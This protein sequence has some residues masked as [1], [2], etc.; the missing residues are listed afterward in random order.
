MWTIT[1][2]T[3]LAADRAWVRDENG[4]DTW[5][6][7][8]KGT[9]HIHDDGV[10][11]IADEQR[12]VLLLPEFLGEPAESSLV[13]DADLM[14]KKLTT[15]VLVHGHAQAPHAEPVTELD[16]R[17]Q[18]E[19]IDKT[20]RVFGPRQWEGTLLGEVVSAPQPFTEIPLDYEHAFGGMD[21]EEVSEFPVGEPRNPVGIGFTANRKRIV[22]LPVANI[23]NPKKRIANWNDRPEPA[24]LGPIPRH[25]PQR[26]QY[27]GTY[28]Q[29]W[30]QS[31]SPLLPHD[32]DERFYQAAPADQQTSSFLR[33]GEQVTLTGCTAEGPLTFHLP[34]LTIGFRTQ[35]LTSRQKTHRGV[36][37][38][39][40][41]EPDER[42][43][44]VVWH[45]HLECHQDEYDLLTTHVDIKRRI[46]EPEPSPVM[47]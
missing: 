2:N 36:M 39:V 27:A 14:H 45:S 34:K 43:V 24:G 40:I 20:I 10:L 21:E 28:D 7:A 47:S 19:D 46:N 42:L 18:V 38:T 16:V 30:E 31:R 17:L 37:H 13:Y 44:I 12:E 5:L 4:A 1:N 33:G 8:V 29:Q 35:F 9:F 11:E 6:V 32:F 23:E 41:V 26:T 22:G 15:D 25:W 3:K